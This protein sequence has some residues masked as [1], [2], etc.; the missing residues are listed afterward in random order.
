MLTRDN[1]GNLPYF[2]IT[3]S[4]NQGDVHAHKVWCLVITVVI[5][6]AYNDP[7]LNHEARNA[8]C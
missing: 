8:L 7:L 4:F 2:T 3:S 6:A 5:Q 1:N